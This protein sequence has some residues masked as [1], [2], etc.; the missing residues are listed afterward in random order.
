M[1]G[2]IA[3]PL[4]MIAGVGISWKEDGAAA[5]KWEQNSNTLAERATVDK[6]SC[7]ID[8]LAAAARRGPGSPFWLRVG[9]DPLCG[10]PSEHLTLRG[11]KRNHINGGL[12][13]DR[14]RAASA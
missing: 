3:V 12:S 10:L 5:E 13:A 14:R 11:L 8:L 7:P 9:T 2:C 1:C 6:D 4:L